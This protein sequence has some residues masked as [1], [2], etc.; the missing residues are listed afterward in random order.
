MRKKKAGS[1]LNRLFDT[2]DN[3]LNVNLNAS[4]AKIPNNIPDNG[5]IL[6]YKSYE[7]QIPKFYEATK[8]Y[9]NSS[10]QLKGGKLFDR[11][12]N[13]I[14]ANINNVSNYSDQFNN[15]GFFDNKNYLL[16]DLNYNTKYKPI[17][18]NTNIKNA[19]QPSYFGIGGNDEIKYV[20]KLLDYI[21]KESYV[22]FTKKNGGD[23]NNYD[24][25]LKTQ[26]LN[27]KSFSY[28][29]PQKKFT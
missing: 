3:D 16:N 10:F 4:D 8:L 28:L 27:I 26:D 11:S 1:F 18:D 20:N 9:Q 6:N 17:F 15:I 2:S 14:N 7:P 29:E 19:P 23:D 5:N 21:I 12:D 13:N 24:I 25:Y 22:K